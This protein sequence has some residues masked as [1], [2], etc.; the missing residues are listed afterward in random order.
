MLNKSLL[1]SNSHS[2]DHYC[3]TTKTIIVLTTNAHC[4]RTPRS[5]VPYTKFNISTLW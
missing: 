5:A 4:G 2:F 3:I 1:T